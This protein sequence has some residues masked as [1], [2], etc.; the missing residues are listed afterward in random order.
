MVR[1]V[2]L[3]HTTGDLRSFVTAVLIF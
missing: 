1:K 3:P 2:Q